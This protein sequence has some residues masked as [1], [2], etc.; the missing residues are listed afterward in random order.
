MGLSSDGDGL[1]V[2]FTESKRLAVGAS[3]S[4][5][6]TRR[7]CSWT[8]P[9]SP[10]V[11]SCSWYS[12]CS[13]RILTSRAPAWRPS[14]SSW[15]RWRKSLKGRRARPSHRSTRRSGLTWQS[16]TTS[17]RASLTHSRSS[18]CSAGDGHSEL[19]TPHSADMI[20]MPITWANR[21]TVVASVS[22]SSAGTRLS[23][24]YRA[25]STCCLVA[26]PRHSS[27]S[28]KLSSIS[29]DCRRAGLACVRRCMVFR[30]LRLVSTTTCGG[31][32]V[33]S[34]DSRSARNAPLWT[35]TSWFIWSW[36]IR[37]ST[38]TRKWRV[39]RNSQPRGSSWICP[40]SSASSCRVSSCCW[41]AALASP[42]VVRQAMMQS[43]S[44][45]RRPSP[46]SET[47]SAD[48]ACARAERTE[49]T[50]CRTSGWP[51]AATLGYS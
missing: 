37:Y 31:A 15:D 28:E 16:R 3:A 25:Y 24:T 26:S 36:L 7:S 4:F 23:S 33:T 13:N 44:S 17:S 27:T 19:S 43:A 9:Y 50:W 1:W 11:L 45:V 5:G 40:S 12:G 51:M 47:V 42:T 30:Q 6:C 22:A 8:M 32:L 34:N 2:R 10:T 14:R 39:R 48:R 29:S 20:A 49:W 18:T 21:S 38:M 41:C 46:R 35:R